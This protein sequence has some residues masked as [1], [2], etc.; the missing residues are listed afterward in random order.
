VLTLYFEKFVN[1]INHLKIWH[2]VC[3]LSGSPHW[4]HRSTINTDP[5]DPR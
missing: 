2:G 5:K 3:L 1:K 4:A